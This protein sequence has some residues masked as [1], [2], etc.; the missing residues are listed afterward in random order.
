MPGFLF[1]S[2]P[3]DVKAERKDERM[4]RIRLFDAH[5]HLNME[6]WT[7]EE[8]RE[9]LRETEEAGIFVMNAGDSASSSLLAVRLAEEHP[10][11]FA[12]TGIHPSHASH[13]TEEDLRTVYRLAD[14]PRVRAVG[15]IG[16]DFYYGKD[17]K[18][19]QLALFRK[20][21]RFAL[22]KK[23]PVMIHTRDADALTMDILK[24]EGIHGFIMHGFTGSY[25]IACQALS[26]G[27]MISLSPNAERAKSFEKLLALPFLIETD[28]KAGDAQRNALGEWSRKLSGHIGI[29][30]G[31]RCWKMLKDIL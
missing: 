11:C 5:T 13:Y 27:G 4:S 30:T 8:R 18:E 22:E 19:E 2:G 16:L 29:D 6:E 31:E 9:Q 1:L 23:M 26:L 14:H 21:L 24:E 10:W 7:E 20:Q 25:E 28:M 12:S 17:D 15:E 3:A